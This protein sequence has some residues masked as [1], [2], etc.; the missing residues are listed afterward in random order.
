M[1]AQIRSDEHLFAVP[2]FDIKKE[3]IKDFGNEL[4]G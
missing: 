2:K 4:K 1:L 3:D